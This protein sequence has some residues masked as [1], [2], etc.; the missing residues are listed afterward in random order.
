MLAQVKGEDMG[1]EVRTFWFHFG[2]WKYLKLREN[3]DRHSGTLYRRKFLGYF[4]GDDIVALYVKSWMAFF[5]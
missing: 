5:V 4:D 3:F 2:W 1:A